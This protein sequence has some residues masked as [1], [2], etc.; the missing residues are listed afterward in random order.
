MN[1]HQKSET[2]AAKFLDSELRYSTTPNMHVS[3][4][5]NGLQDS[6]KCP[7]ETKFLVPSCSGVQSQSNFPCTKNLF[8]HIDYLRLRDQI[9]CS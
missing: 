9:S 3:M 6:H 8:M 1:V 5:R 7:Q 4:S 2:N